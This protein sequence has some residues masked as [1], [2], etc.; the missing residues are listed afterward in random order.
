MLVDQLIAVSK[1]AIEPKVKLLEQSVTKRL[2]LP[3][4]KPTLK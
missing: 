3:A 1:S 4:A 2:D